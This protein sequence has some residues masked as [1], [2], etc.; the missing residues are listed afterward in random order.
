[1]TLFFLSSGTN[2][3]C[4]PL[5][6]M[7]LTMSF[8]LPSFSR[9]ARARWR[10]RRSEPLLRFLASRWPGGRPRIDKAVTLPRRWQESCRNRDRGRWFWCF[11]CRCRCRVRSWIQIAD[12]GFRI[13]KQSSSRQPRGQVTNTEN[14]KLKIFHGVKRLLHTRYRVSVPGKDR[15]AFYRDVLGLELTR[16]HSSPRGSKLVFFKA[17]GS[18]EEI[19]VASSMGAARSR[20]ATILR[21]WPSRWTIS[22]PSPGTPPSKGYPR[23]PMDRLPTG[24]GSVIAV[25]RRARRVPRSSSFSAP[26]EDTRP[27]EPEAESG[28]P[29][30]QASSAIPH[31]I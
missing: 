6:P 14:R 20:S 2:P 8:L 30:P 28:D 13:E 4:W 25:H 22:T 18:E 16:R 29:Q 7:A 31:G 23:F 1:M 26:H 15:Q 3:C 11:A 24:S 27:A 9:T 17:P 19:E 12:F 10:P 5:T 21:T